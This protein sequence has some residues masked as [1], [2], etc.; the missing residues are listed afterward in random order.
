MLAGWVRRKGSDCYRMALVVSIFISIVVHIPANVTGY[1]SY[2]SGNE[3]EGFD[4]WKGGY[5][6]AGGNQG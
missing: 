3:D 4:C 6:M 2:D 5:L 1:A